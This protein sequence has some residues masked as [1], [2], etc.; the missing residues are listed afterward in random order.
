MTAGFP[1]LF[2]PQSN[3]QEERYKESRDQVEHRTGRNGYGKMSGYHTEY[4]DTCRWR[5]SE[6]EEHH[7]HDDG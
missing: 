4:D 7:L 2:S 1:G 6:V 3:R 5:K